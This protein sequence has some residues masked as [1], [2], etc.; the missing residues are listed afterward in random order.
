MTGGFSFCGVDIADLGIEY[1]PELEDTYVYKSAKHKI[2]E[3]VF[4]GHNG[5]YFYGVSK[6]PKEFILRCFFEEKEIDKGI[7]ARVGSLFQEG[8]SG[9][10]IFKRRPWCYYFAT[11]T[12]FD[13]SEISN[14]L[15]G[16]I[17]ITMKAYYPYARSDLT[18]VARNHPDHF[19]IMENTGFLEKESMMPPTDLCTAPITAEKD[20]LLYNP[21]TEEA[22]LGIEIAGDVGKGVEIINHTT[23][24]TCRFV[25]MSK[26]QFD[27]ENT[28]L[29]LDGMNGKCLTVDAALSEQTKGKEGR[30]PSFLYHDEGFLSLAPSFPIKRELHVGVKKGILYTANKLYDRNTGESRENAEADLIGKYIWLNNWYEIS[31]VGGDEYS[32]GQNEHIL[33]LKDSVEDMGITSTVICTMNK[34]T[35]RPV[36]T[37]EITR[38]R[39]IYKPTFS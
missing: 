32:A 16:I 28:Y 13:Q 21:G 27:G 5:G 17:K 9:K 11:V 37:M 38:L 7:M 8:R 19:R 29:L 22:P 20:F 10:L 25:A 12:D 23:G 2:Y 6:E 24:Q 35:I 3:E 33:T 4:D 36:S 39:F 34:L 14:Y 31:G 15:N 1:A 18:T 26:A 30:T